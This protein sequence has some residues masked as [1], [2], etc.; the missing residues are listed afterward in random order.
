VVGSDDTIVI[1]DWL[2]CVKPHTV[3]LAW[4]CAA[5][6]TVESVG[7]EKGWLLNGARNGLRLKLSRSAGQVALVQ[8][9]IDALVMVAAADAGYNRPRI[10]MRMP[11]LLRRVG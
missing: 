7:D 9:R 3:S 10:P 4:H 1:E 11:M 5:G 8:G 2:E 6:I